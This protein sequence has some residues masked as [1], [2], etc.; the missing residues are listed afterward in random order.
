[1][2]AAQ[3]SRLAASQ[4]LRGE[5]MRPPR[6][7]HPQSAP[8]IGAANAASQQARGA[9][10]SASP[11]TIRAKAAA[12]SASAQGSFRCLGNARP[13]GASASA[14]ANTASAIRPSAN[15]PARIAPGHPP[16]RSR[17]AART[18]R[19]PAAEGPRIVRV[20]KTA[21]PPVAIAPATP[22]QPARSTSFGPAR[23]APHSA[24]EPKR[25][26]AANARM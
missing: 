18:E 20:A 16:T 25:H 17:A 23:A 26:A 7:D 5:S 15:P 1:M 9:T 19:L 21:I 12:P 6:S 11:A 8:I 22:T 24:A 3:A 14:A 4:S 2:P 10:R 13:I